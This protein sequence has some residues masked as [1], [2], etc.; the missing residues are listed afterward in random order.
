[1]AD[2]L[3]REF[4]NDYPPAAGWALRVI[5]LH[6][7]LVG[8]VRPAPRTL[9]G[10]VGFVLLI[11]CANVANL[12]CSRARRRGSGIGTRRALGAGRGRIVG[13]CHRDA[14]CWRAPAAL[15]GLLSRC[16]VST[17]IS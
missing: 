10:A 8:D 5:P 1:M 11:A 13:S 7:D 12:R 9:L 15:L 4:P 16:G 17:P 6:D 2:R 3:R 14:C